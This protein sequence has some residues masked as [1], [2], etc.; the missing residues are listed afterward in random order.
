MT[1]IR[2]PGNGGWRTLTDPQREVFGH[3]QRQDGTFVTG[4]D[5][6]RIVSVT[7][8]FSE[9][10][11]APTW[12]K[13]E[14]P[15][16]PVRVPRQPATECLYGHDVSPSSGNLVIWGGKRNCLECTRIRKRRYRAEKR[17]L[18]KAA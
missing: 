18:A 17:R 7:K 2:L 9:F 14:K 10:R 15:P 11:D 6:D 16:K 4:A 13:P 3:L 5:L 8:E 12:P 1:R